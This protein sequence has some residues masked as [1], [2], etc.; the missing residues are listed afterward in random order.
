[1]TATTGVEL[2]VVLLDT[3]HRTDVVALGG[4]KTQ[5]TTIVGYAVTAVLI[6]AT[7]AVPVFDQM[8]TFLDVT[9]ANTRDTQMTSARTNTGTPARI[10]SSPKDI[11]KVPS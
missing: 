6:A 2:Y 7:P 8:V 3:S 11:S 9:G 1:V 4:S 5:A 10:G